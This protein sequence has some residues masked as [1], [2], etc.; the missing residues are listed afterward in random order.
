MITYLIQ[1]SLW[2][3]L[4]PGVQVSVKDQVI[5]YLVPAIIVALGLT[6]LNPMEQKVRPSS[7]ISP[8][9]SILFVVISLLF[10]G[11]VVQLIDYPSPLTF[12][13]AM[14]LGSLFFLGARSMGRLVL[15]KNVS[16]SVPNRPVSEVN[17]SVMIS[18]EKKKRLAEVIMSILFVLVVVIVAQMW[19]IPPTGYASNLF[20][21]DLGLVFL[22]LGE[23]ISL[24]HYV[25]YKK[26]T[27]KEE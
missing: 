22:M 23:S 6:F 16:R 2:G 19:T 21:V 13:I 27:E 24:Y 10:S 12:S 11:A 1:T 18:N 3:D 15:N 4:A 26:P 25:G 5:A 17:T 9:T 20:G 7:A 8:M 14:F